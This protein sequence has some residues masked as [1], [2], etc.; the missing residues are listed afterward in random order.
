MDLNALKLDFSN[1]SPEE[2]VSEA[3]RRFQEEF[4]QGE[5]ARG[6]FMMEE[7]QRVF[8]FQD[9]FEHAFFTSSNRSR[10]QL[11]KD[12]PDPDRMERLLWIKPVLMGLVEGTECWLVTSKNDR[13]PQRLYVVVQ[14]SY[15]IWLESRP[16][17]A[18]KFSTAYCAGRSDIKRYT[19]GGV[20][21]W[22]K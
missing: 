9:R 20:R 18:W 5:G 6:D 2:M 8:I 21:I 13:R 15:V 10:H 22:A 17:G 11:A 12:K 19:E 16:D 7:G 3:R 14:D 1:K 4:F